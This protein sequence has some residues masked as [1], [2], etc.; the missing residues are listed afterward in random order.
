MTKA[1]KRELATSLTIFTF[2]VI[3]M[4][5]VMM[6]FHFFDD[7]VKELYEILGLFFVLVIFFH[8]FY[9]F[10]SMKNYFTKKMFGFSALAIT[11]VSLVFILNTPDGQNPKRA[12]IM[13][14]LDANLESS[15]MILNKDIVDVKSRLELKGITIQESDTIKSVAQNNKMSPFELVGII[16]E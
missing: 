3:G 13:S 1:S 5:G 15:V 12:I 9:N 8:V 14:M 11:I 4:S 16:L 2:L 10:K 6:F 7:Y